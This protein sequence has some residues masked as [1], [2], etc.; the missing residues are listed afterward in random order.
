MNAR[1]AFA[2]IFAPMSAPAVVATPWL[3]LLLSDPAAGLAQLGGLRVAVVVASA[4]SYLGFILLGV[5]SLLMLYRHRKLTLVSVIGMGVL[6]GL[7]VGLA[8]ALLFGVAMGTLRSMEWLEIPPIAVFGAFLGGC[9]A[10]SFALL[11]GIPAK[12]SVEVHDA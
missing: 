1:L 2:A 6:C 10:L 12:S 4:F 9:V 3:A 11:A 8:F 5:P 7:A